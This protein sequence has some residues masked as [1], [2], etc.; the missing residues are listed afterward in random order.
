MDYIGQIHIMQGEM[1]EGMA[2]FKEAIEIKP[3]FLEAREQLLLLFTRKY[4]TFIRRIR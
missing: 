4:G 1:E 3:D 2:C